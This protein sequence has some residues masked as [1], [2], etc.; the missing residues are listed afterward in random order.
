[1]T[2]LERLLLCVVVK[3]DANIERH[4][5]GLSSFSERL[6]IGTEEV[7]NKERRSGKQR[8]YYGFLYDWILQGDKQRHTIHACLILSLISEK[9]ILIVS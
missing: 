2:K 4:E 7:H 1:M 8:V 5:S 9:C 6:D 3:L